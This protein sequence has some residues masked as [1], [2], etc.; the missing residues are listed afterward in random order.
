ME[1]KITPLS[2]ISVYNYGWA[3]ELA[4]VYGESVDNFNHI[5]EA[6]V[7]Y[8]AHSNLTHINN[9]VESFQ[10]ALQFLN[11]KLNAIRKTITFWD[12]YQI[13]GVLD[14]PELATAAISQLPVNSSIM[15]TTQARWESKTL[16]PGDV[17]VKDF[18]NQLHHIPSVST[19]YYYPK[20]LTQ[21]DG[22]NITITY[23]YGQT[24]PVSGAY[25][26][27]ISDATHLPEQAYET[28]KANLT[29]EQEQFCYAINQAL[30]SGASCTFSQ[31]SY[32]GTVVWPVIKTY[33]YTTNNSTAEIGEQIDIQDK[34]TIAKNSTTHQFTLTNESTVDVWLTVK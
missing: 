23:Q 9:D 7:I 21:S 13:N 32:N 26:Y 8:L 34:L 31:T 5:A 10:E 3:Q 1:L 33:L 24:S 22:N 28:L 15:V 19:G 27:P 30:D 12:A 17:L 4:T 14:N 11:A 18:Y 25:D 29:L 20:Q 6:L 2:H 16:Y